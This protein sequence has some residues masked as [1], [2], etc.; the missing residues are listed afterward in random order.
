MILAAG[1]GTRLKPFSLHTPKPLFTINQQAVL[2]IAIA[3]LA[4]AGCTAVVINTHHLAEQI[5]SHVEN[6]QYPFP[7]LT[8]NEP[9]ILGTGGGIRNVADFWGDEPLLVI[10]ADIVCDLDLSQVSRFHQVHGCPVTMV[11][12]DYPRFNRVHVD[13]DNHVV[14]LDPHDA[15]RAEGCR[16]LAFS[17]IHILDP[18]VRAFLPENGFA[19]IIDTYRLML[20]SGERIKA[21]LMTQHYWQDIGTPEDYRAAVFAQMAPL[22]FKSAFN[23]PV[24]RAIDCRQLHGDGSDRSWHRLVH[25]PD[26]LIMVDHGIRA[27]RQQQ[28]VDA[29]VAIGK[30]LA[31][32][33]VPVPRIFLYDTFA[34]MVF[35]EDLGDQH[36]QGAVQSAHHVQRLALYRQVIDRWIHMALAGASGFD[37]S[38]TFQSPCYDRDLI[39]EKE[40]RYFC[41]AFVNR[42]LGKPDP[43]D[44]LASEFESLAD[45]VTRTQVIGFMHRDLQSRNIMLKKG[46]VY[47]I[48]FQGG[49]LGPLQYDL[50]SLLIDP[51]VAL[52]PQEQDRLLRYTVSR[53]VERHGVDPDQFESGYR[54]CALT[55]NLQIL[56]AFAFL[57]GAKGKGQFAQ[58]IPA[59]VFSLSQNLKNKRAPAMPGLTAMIDRI[60]AER[61]IIWN[62]S[63]S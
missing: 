7:V 19:N 26:H 1:L 36:L 44:Q 3:G 21:Y 39:L 42:Y 25:G 52:S 46:R 32:R 38:W 57:S 35:L 49:R 45:C 54:A 14:A 43:Y 24:Q 53:L 6:Q 31:R 23:R 18:K 27:A 13:Q 29:Y 10:N 16:L 12:H 11:M 56:G 62:P 4:A 28:E 9:D 48:D 15:V 8:R 17:G 58:Y 20:A 33:Q 55:R 41:D 60:V 22:A 63:K 59:A 51:Y 37:T 34:G 47:F 40:C 50:A 5:E 30:H 2:D 61:R